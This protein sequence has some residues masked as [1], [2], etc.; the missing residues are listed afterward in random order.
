MYAAYAAPTEVDSLVIN[1]FDVVGAVAAWGERQPDADGF[2]AEHAQVV[3]L[4]YPPQA[5]AEVIMSVAALAAAY[6][7]DLVALAELPAAAATHGKRLPRPAAVAAPARRGTLANLMRRGTPAPAA[8]L[9]EPAPGWPGRVVELTVASRRLTRDQLYL[10][11][12]H[13]ESTLCHLRVFSAPDSPA[14]VIAGNLNGP[15]GK[16]V[17]NAATGLAADIATRLIP[18]GPFSFIEHSPR[19]LFHSGDPTV[20]AAE[21]KFTPVTF[22]DE[23]SPRFGIPLS[24]DEVEAIVRQPVVVFPAGYYTPENV[25]LV[26]S[27]PHAQIA[28]DSLAPSCPD[29]GRAYPLYCAQHQSACEARNA[30]QQRR[31]R[32]PPKRL[33]HACLRDGSYEGRWHEEPGWREPPGALTVNIAGYR[34]RIHPAPGHDEFAWGYGGSGSYAVARAI[35]ADWHGHEVA[36]PLREAFAEQV[37]AGLAKDEFTLPFEQV[38]AW[39]SEQ[40]REARGLVFVA[41][42]AADPGGPRFAHH[43]GS[44]IADDL[45]EQGFEAYLPRYAIGSGR[46]D[47]FG[48]EVI[49]SHRGALA[50]AS[51]IVVPYGLADT[52]PPSLE[53]ALALDYARDD[54]DIAVVIAALDEAVALPGTDLYF[55]AMGATATPPAD[56]NTRINGQPIA[57]AV[58]QLVEQSASRVRRG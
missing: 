23:G 58:R 11:L 8:D 30:R 54:R 39:L 19:D 21:R 1:G 9:A 35:L 6:D 36:S 18:E 2:R 37:I 34:S 25:E 44:L 32:Q 13:G 33:A 4:A 47:P 50:R 17:T 51:L 27:K 16:S 38:A 49:A 45:V 15:T 53:A 10:H 40:C 42:T 56:A 22:D 12:T 52:A 29:H 26:K 28:A 57:D 24:Q 41:S 43:V 7:V 31:F 55:A 14:V 20:S 46:C 3:A 48:A 5:T